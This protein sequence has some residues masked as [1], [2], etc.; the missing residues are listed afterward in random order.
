MLL[1]LLTT[2]FLFSSQPFIFTPQKNYSIS[3]LPDFYKDIDFET[4]HEIKKDCPAVWSDKAP[5][6]TLYC[7]YG[8]KVPTPE[9]FTFGEGEFPDTFPKYNLG[10]GDGTVNIRSLEGCKEYIGKQVPPISVKEYPGAEHLNII[11]DKRVVDDITKIL[12][13][14]E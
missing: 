11:G 13:G 7:F 5:N 4:G 1:K 3:N 10:D 9:S 2:F 14:L 6:V 8:V 12:D